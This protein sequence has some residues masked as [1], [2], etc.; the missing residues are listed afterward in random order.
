MAFVTSSSAVV[1]IN[2]DAQKIETGMRQYKYTL[3]NISNYLC[4][5]AQHRS[6][7]HN[8]VDVCMDIRGDYPTSAFPGM[9]Y[10]A[11]APAP[12]YNLELCS[13]I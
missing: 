9:D 4:V 13:A 10:W 3:T 2:T 12:L 8:G 7:D 5:C 11:A 6:S 1:L